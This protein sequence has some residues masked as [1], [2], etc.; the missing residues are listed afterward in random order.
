[1][2]MQEPLIHL[3]TDSDDP[4]PVVYARR[5]AEAASRALQKGECL[6]LENLRFRDAEEAGDPAFA[7]QLAKNGDVYVNDAFGAAH[8]AHA[9]VSG[10]PSL[11]PSAMGLLMQKELDAFHKVLHS[12]ARPFVAIHRPSKSRSSIPNSRMPTDANSISSRPAPST[13]HSSDA[14]DSSTPRVA[15]S[16]WRPAIGR[17]HSVISTQF[18]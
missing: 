17:G 16:R 8:R 10:V 11:L 14:I 12:P 15:P 13:S 3:D 18:L 5:L 4:S 1:M 7:A 9:S 2:S 6:V